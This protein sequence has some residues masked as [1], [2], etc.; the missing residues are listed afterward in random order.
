[1][2]FNFRNGLLLAATPEPSTSGLQAS[3]PVPLAS[4]SSI[5]EDGYLGDCSSDGGNEKNFPMPPDTLKRLTSKHCSCH[6][7]EEIF[8][9]P[10]P[11]RPPLPEPPKNGDD[12]DDDDV[13]VI[14]PP[15]GIGFSNIQPEYFAS[16]CGYQVSLG[17]SEANF[18]LS[19][20]GSAI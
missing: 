7:A 19:R 6:P 14:E 2:V 4:S 15:A 11:I 8:P 16:S 10:A 17:L 13:V 12:E 20:I 9:P 18:F 3:V 5:A 1:M